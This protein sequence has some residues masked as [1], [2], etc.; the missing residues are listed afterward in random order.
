MYLVVDV[1]VGY[2]TLLREYIYERR[3]GDD[4]VACLA[5]WEDSK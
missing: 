5:G 2:G 4:S 3:K 1:Y